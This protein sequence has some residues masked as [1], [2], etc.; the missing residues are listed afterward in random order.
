M[1]EKPRLFCAC[2]IGKTLSSDLDDTFDDLEEVSR[3]SRRTEV[4][5]CLACLAR[6][7]NKQGWEI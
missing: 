6:G 3:D 5:A 4:L 7:V 1:K 2:Q